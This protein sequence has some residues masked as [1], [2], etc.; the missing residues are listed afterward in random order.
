MKKSTKNRQIINN[1]YVNEKYDDMKSMLNL[2]RN[3]KEQSEKFN[4]EEYEEYEEEETQVKEEK[5]KEYSVSGGKIVVHGMSEQELMLTDEE[6][7]AYQETMED[8]VE[9]V[10]DMA[11][12]HELNIYKNNVEWSGDLLK[13]D[14]RFYY[15]IVEV[16]GTYIGNVNMLKI[17]KEL[18][19]TLQKVK[20]YYATFEVK[21][22]KILASRRTTELNTG[23]GLGDDVS[24]DEV[25]DET[26]VV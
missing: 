22:A 21:W 12:F 4:D 6:K 2:V 7:S 14:I 18:M 1:V 8:F 10:S 16:E 5:T 23:E 26:G 17:N 19:E 25:E 3:L 11:E 24:A 13:Y 9:Q 15:S 20:D